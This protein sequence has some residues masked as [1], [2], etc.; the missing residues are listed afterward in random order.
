MAAADDKLRNLRRFLLK[1]ASDDAFRSELETADAD[2]LREKLRSEYGVD[3]EIPQNRL[4]PS[5][6]LCKELLVMSC[7]LE[8]YADVSISDALF[9]PIFMVVGHA[10]PLAVTAEDAVGAG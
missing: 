10:M 8:E 9:I 2:E 3:I 5:K 4:V 7:Y 1:A 6:A